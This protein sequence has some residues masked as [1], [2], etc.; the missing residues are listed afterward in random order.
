MRQI[1][2]NCILPLIL[3]SIFSCN[4]QKQIIKNTS[5]AEAVLVTFDKADGDYN[6]IELPQNIKNNYNWLTIKFDENIKN[7]IEEIF[8]DNEPF[9]IEKHRLNNLFYKYS[10]DQKGVSLF[11]KLL[12]NKGCLEILLDNKYNLVILSK[13]NHD[14]KLEYSG[15]YEIIWKE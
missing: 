15:Y 8:F 7:S 13:S 9:E 14:W 1:Y 4:A 11:V 2:I 10:K 6:T 3:L 12:D 5:C